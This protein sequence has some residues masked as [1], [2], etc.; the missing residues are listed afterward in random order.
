[1][2]LLIVYY[3]HTGNNRLL[4]EHLGRMF[5]AR[6]VG[7]TEQRKRTRATILIDMLFRRHPA[8]HPVGVS[9]QDFDAVLLVAPVWNMSVAGPMQTAIVQMQDALTAYFFV[10]LCGCERPGQSAHLAGELTQLAGKAPERVWELHVCDLVPPAKRHKVT[11]VSAYRVTENEL[12]AFRTKIAEIAACLSWCSSSHC[13]AET[14]SPSRSL[15][16]CGQ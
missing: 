15:P 5:S 14:R 7:V 11:I 13:H 9:P 10:S 8:I 12:N 1:M 2:N 16:D 3:S 6:V 4:A